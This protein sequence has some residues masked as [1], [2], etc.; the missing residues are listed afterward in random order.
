MTKAILFDFWG[1]LAETGI[2]S[3][4]KQ[5]KEILNIKMPFSEYVTLMEK[6][7]MTSKFDSLK[8]A[9]RNVCKEFKIDSD[10]EK[11]E[12]L[13]GMWNKSWMLAKPYEEVVE[14]LEKL[15]KNY[16]L[17]LISNTD[18]FSTDQ[19][20]NKFG[21]RSLFDAIFLSYDIHL[22]KTDRN[23]FKHILRVMDLNAE[24]CLVV[25]DSIQSDIMAAKKVGL[26]AVLIDRKN[27]RNFHLKIEN[28]KELELFLTNE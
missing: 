20:L 26:R 21:L 15:K 5:V 10:E 17:I 13:I 22:I 6:A 11:L 9:F 8:D 3:P 2:G 19:V 14:A 12:E 28:L 27:T 23:F 25:G 18:C 1:T 4:T 24:D 7:M 16:K